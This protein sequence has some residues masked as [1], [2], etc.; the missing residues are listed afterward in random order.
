MKCCS[1][2]FQD[3][4]L[5][6]FIEE[7]GDNGNCEICGAESVKTI[8]AQDLGGLFEP[9]IDLYEPAQE[10]THIGGSETLA[11]CMENW[12]VFSEKLDTNQQNSLLDEIMFGGMRYKRRFEHHTSTEGWAD[13][14]DSLYSTSTG[15]IWNEFAE[16]LKRKR[17]FIPKPDEFQH[18]SNPADWLPDAL[19]A[20]VVKVT[21]VSVFFRAREGSVRENF[22]HPKALPATQ[23]ST[24]PPEKARRNRANA[25]GIPY[26]YVAEEEATAI[27][28]CRPFVGAKVSVCKTRAKK[29]LKVADLT[30]FHGVGSPFGHGDLDALIERNTLLNALNEEL[31]KPVNPEENE[32]E[33]VP[34]QYLAELIL[35]AGYD[36]IR[37]R[38]A[39]NESG[40]NL[41]FFNPD[42]LEVQSDTR[43]VEIKSIEVH[44]ASA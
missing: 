41:V 42:D 24:P 23:M 19:E 10:D 4:Y 27:A 17:R 29:P 13:K 5:L 16:H 37:Y 6:K 2:C 40:R 20:A 15:D 9:L 31:A 44:Y 30:K 12:Q 28:E 33:Y 38:S 22:G 1:E 32:V 21:P 35:N 34:T 11:E 8:D 26:F 7:H 14:D 18:L 3:H 43:L 25:A 36:G 39:V